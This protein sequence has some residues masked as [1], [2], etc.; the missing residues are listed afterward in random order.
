MKQRGLI[1]VE[2]GKRARSRNL[3][4]EAIAGKLRKTI[5]FPS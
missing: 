5:V 4:K 3:K 2:S 1:G